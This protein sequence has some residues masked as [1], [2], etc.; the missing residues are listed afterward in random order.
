MD[1]PEPILASSLTMA[2]TLG[3]WWLVNSTFNIDV[4]NSVC[5]EPAPATR[6]L[7]NRLL[8]YRNSYA[9]DIS[10]LPLARWPLA[11]RVNTY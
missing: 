2:V 8:K 10:N 7:Y 9:R 1:E 6:P 3:V 5:D 4:Y 11:A